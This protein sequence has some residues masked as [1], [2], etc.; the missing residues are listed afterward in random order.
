M[1]KPDF[2]SLLAATP[3][4]RSRSPNRAK[5]IPSRSRPCR[6]SSPALLA[7]LAT[8]HVSPESVNGYPLDQPKTSLPFLYPPFLDQPTHSLTKRS[9]TPS[10][11]SAASTSTSSSGCHPDGA[12]LPDKYVQGDDGY[13][14][15]TL[16]W[17]LYGSTSCSVSKAPLLPPPNLLS[18]C[19]LKP[20]P[21][22]FPFFCITRIHVIARLRYQTRISLTTMTQREQYPPTSPPRHLM[23]LMFRHYQLVGP[24]SGLTPQLDAIP[25]SPFPYPW[26]SRSSS[27]P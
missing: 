23:T 1:A 26:L 16:P 7:L 24:A 4:P 2:A 11:S 3:P 10:T 21:S 13:W 19:P 22:P 20:P 9:D 25:S 17:S 8:V 5:R 18:P 27:S 15:K 12:N 6:R 14:H